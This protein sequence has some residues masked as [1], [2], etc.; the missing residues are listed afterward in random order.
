MRW[1]E[2]LLPQEKFGKRR[3]G[4][5]NYEARLEHNQFNPDLAHNRG[6]RKG[7]EDFLR[8]FPPKQTLILPL[9]LAKEEATDGRNSSGFHCGNGGATEWLNS[10]M[11]IERKKRRAGI[12]PP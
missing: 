11:I 9:S 12:N 10:W 8:L 1:R 3:E 4:N 5:R 6:Y 2:Y 7:D